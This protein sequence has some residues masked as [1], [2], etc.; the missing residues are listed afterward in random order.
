[1]FLL[2]V[3]KYIYIHTYVLFLMYYFQKTTISS[4]EILV[5]LTLRNT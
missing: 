2:I 3:T 5:I 4:I 1:M